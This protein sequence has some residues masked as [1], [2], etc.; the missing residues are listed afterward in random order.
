LVELVTTKNREAHER[1]LDSMFEDRKAVFVDLL[2]WN[3]PHD[4]RCERDEL[5]TLTLNI[6]L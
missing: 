2:K 3:V 1:L 5:T 4:G 6:L